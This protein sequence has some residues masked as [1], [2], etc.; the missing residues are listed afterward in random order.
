MDFILPPT[1]AAGNR[2]HLVQVVLHKI[3][4]GLRPALLL[5]KCHHIGIRHAFG[6]IVQQADTGHIGHGFDIES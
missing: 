3:A 2:H 1:H 5:C 6:Q 4:A